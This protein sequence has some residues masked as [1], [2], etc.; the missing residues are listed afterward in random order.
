MGEY[1]VSRLI[2]LIETSGFIH[3]MAKDFLKRLFASSN[4][5]LLP[6]VPP[7]SL[8]ARLMVPRFYAVNH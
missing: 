5:G 1:R 7:P 3:R 4:V 6:Q 8:L 2:C